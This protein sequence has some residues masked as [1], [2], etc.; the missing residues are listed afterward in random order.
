MNKIKILIVCMVVF[1]ATEN[2]YAAEWITSDDLIK[3]DFH[4]MTAEER[5]G[6]KEETSDSMEA[7]YMLKNNIRWYYHNGDLSIPSNFSNKHTLVVKGNLTINGDYDDYSAGDG[8]LIV[9]GNV[10]VDNFINHDFA[11]VK[12]EM[13]AKGLVYADYNDHNFEVMKG[14]TARGIIV[15]DKATQFE[16]NNAEFYINE[17]TSNENYDWDA[18]IRKAY[19]LFE[20]D[21][22]EITEIETDNVLNAYPDYDS[23]AASIVQGLPLFRDKP[24]SGLSEK[25]QWIE[26]GKVEKFAAG[27]VKHEDP[28]VA[29][30]LTRMESLPTDVMLQLLQHPD[31]QTREYMAQRWP[32]RQMHLLTAPF[33][34][35]QAVAKGLIKNSDISPEVNEKLMSTPVESVQLEQ[36][37]QDNL[38]PEIIALLSQSPFPIVRK[39]LVS[40]Y[41]Y[42][43]LAPTSVVDELINSDDDE[44]RERIAGA[45]L[46]TRQAVALSNDQS[47]KVREA[48]AHALAELKVTRLSAN[49][50][51]PDIER[52]ADQMYLDNK[53]HK[54]IVMALFIALPEA[55][56]LSLAKE[57]IQHLREGAR[58][59][60][61]TEVIN[62]L[63]THHD[64]PAVWNE[65]AHDKL[66][67]LEYKKKL[68]QRTLQL[69]M[70]KRQED[71]EQAYDI[72][73][74]L[75]DNG[76]VDEAMLNDAIDLLPDLPAEYRY[77]MRNQLFDKNDLPSEIITRLD[78]QYRFNADWAL[79]V[80][81]MTNSNRR[82]CDRGLRR[83]NDDDSVIL[84]ELDKLTDKPDDEFWLALLQSRHEQLRKTAL[85]NAH[86]PTSAFT[87]LVT[88]QDRQGAIANP[89]LPAEVKTAWLK[90]DPSLLLFA[91]HPD[92]Q[93]L[94]ELVKTG[95]TRQIR[96]EA[97]NKLEEL[98]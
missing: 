63:L 77:R 47:L 20:P 32:A 49:M 58:Y 16:V 17:D 88:P 91:D 6:V 30:F 62:Y 86:T 54:N 5:N 27:N 95:S 15:S 22:Y 36:A 70:S 44:L 71:Q 52:I 38:S 21:L 90:E 45:D 9:L 46:T 3:S 83:W 64:N 37:R 66:L 65:L 19:S 85:I 29:R 67:P 97:R 73:L 93:Q 10:I 23:V 11:Y 98:K 2:V 31:D 89:Q 72:Q 75:I 48:V 40:Q 94:R 56:Q 41:D 50:S 68:W 78:K 60:T 18:N 81:D 76:M 33:I 39:T 80:T 55:R 96:S 53:D 25:L 26:Q 42:A 12:G 4:I 43:W 7:S 59:L 84:I 51:I 87:A 92:P 82:Q 1:I 61:S 24:V 74:E 8:Q 35:D 14:I 34:K 13:Q 28:L 79:S 57:D 69:M